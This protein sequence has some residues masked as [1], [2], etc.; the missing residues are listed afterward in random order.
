MSS[1][2]NSNICIKHDDFV[3]TITLQCKLCFTLT[4]RYAWPYFAA[5]NITCTKRFLILF[6]KLKSDVH[7]RSMQTCFWQPTENCLQSGLAQIT[8]WIRVLTGTLVLLS[9]DLTGLR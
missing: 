2:Y 8:L 4:R 7:N 5:S 1:F 6:K 9:F 3:V